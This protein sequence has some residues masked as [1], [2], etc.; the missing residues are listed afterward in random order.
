MG[1][2]CAPRA[3]SQCLSDAIVL[4]VALSG[5]FAQLDGATALRKDRNRLCPAGAPR[6]IWANFASPSTSTMVPTNNDLWQH[7]HW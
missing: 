7:G 6:A 4:D 5:L 2:S 3:V 1:A